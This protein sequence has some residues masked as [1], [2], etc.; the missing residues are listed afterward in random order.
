MARQWWIRPPFGQL[1]TCAERNT[2]T[3]GFSEHMRE[4]MR[5]DVC[6]TF[7]EFGAFQLGRTTVTGSRCHRGIIIVTR[8]GVHAATQPRHQVHGC[9]WVEPTQ[10]VWLYELAIT[11]RR[12]YD[13]FTELVLNHSHQLHA[14]RCETH[15]IDRA[16]TT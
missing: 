16:R 8:A 3:D 2:D 5:Q 7:L 12:P 4:A 13:R 10:S 14:H 11:Y 9:A 6:G 1:T 15:S